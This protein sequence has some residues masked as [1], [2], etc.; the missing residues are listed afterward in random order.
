MGVV[1][2]FLP[3]EYCPDLKNGQEVT[4]LTNSPRNGRGPGENK[5]TT[6]KSGKTYLSTL[7]QAACSFNVEGSGALKQLD[8]FETYNFD[9]FNGGDRDIGSSNIALLDPDTFNGGGVS[10]VAVMGSKAG[11]VYIMDANNLGG[12]MMGEEQ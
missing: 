2:S 3:G 8:W 6:P 4:T 1:F 11:N 10:R 5:G 7:E 9:S 12:F